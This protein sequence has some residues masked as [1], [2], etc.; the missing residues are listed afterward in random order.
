MRRACRP[1]WSTFLDFA[2]V[3]LFIVE[4]T[5]VQ[6]VQDGNCSRPA[7]IARHLC[8]RFISKRVLS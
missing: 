2:R 5:A 4:W 6:G 7:A 8:K 3:I 1:T